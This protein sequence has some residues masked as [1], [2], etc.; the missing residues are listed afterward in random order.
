MMI[1]INFQ[2]YFNILIINFQ[3]D[4]VIIIDVPIQFLMKI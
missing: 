3:E 1:I 2:V 4:F